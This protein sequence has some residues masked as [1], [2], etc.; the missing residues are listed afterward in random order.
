M[1]LHNNTTEDVNQVK[2][3]FHK[4][5][6]C[7]CKNFDQDQVKLDGE[8]PVDNRPSTDPLHHFVMGKKEK[9]VKCDM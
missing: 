7:K 5:D 1:L 3:H 8:G 2:K 6:A 9:K 4:F